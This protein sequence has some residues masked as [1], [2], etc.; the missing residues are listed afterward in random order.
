MKNK[1]P[2]E[3]AS[4]SGAG[5]HRCIWMSAGVI[6]F[7]LCPLDYDCDSCEFDEVMRSQVRSKKGKPRLKSSP[8]ATPER[9]QSPAGDSEKLLFFTFSAVQADKDLHLHPAHLWVRQI[10]AKKWRIGIDQLLAYTLPHPQGIKLP[11]VNQNMTRGHVFAQVLAEPGEVL[12]AAPLS[13]RLVQVNGALSAHPELLQQDPCGEG[14]L[15]VIQSTP[16]PAELEKFH[17]GP[18]GRKFLE[19]EAQHLRFLLKHKGIRVDQ[20]GDTLPDGGLHIKYLR[21]VLPGQVCLR[22]ALEL[23]ASG[24]QAW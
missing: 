11:D 12:L 7:K 17:T 6:S 16:H 10:E 22:L 9:P 19:E 13:G 18:E 4:R 8:P 2:R 1:A 5:Q 23:V 15:A 24:K 21:Q 14:W 20:I 3:H